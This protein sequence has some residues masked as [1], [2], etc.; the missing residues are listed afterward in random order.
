MTD[1]ITSLDQ[2]YVSGDLSLFPD[3]L[4]DKETLYEVTNNATTTLKQGLPF[5]GTNIIVE[6]ASEFPSQGIVRIGPEAGESGNAEFVY[7]GSRTNFVLKELQRGFADSSQYRWPAHTPVIHAVMSEH[8]NATKDA[9]LN[10][11]S[12]VGIET[13]PVENSLSKQVHDLEV[14]YLA[15]KPVFRA[16][17]LKGPPSL[18]VSF[19]NLCG[20]HVIRHLWDFG[21]GTKSIESNPYHTYLT[22]GQYTV[23]LNVITSTG[24]QGLAT[25][26]NYITVSES[27]ILPF[28]Y[29]VQADTTKPAY[30]STTADALVLSGDLT[31]EAATFNFVDQT[32]GNILQRY[33][34]FDDGEYEFVDDP[35]IHA[36]THVYQDP[37]EYQ[38]SLLLIYSDEK[39]SRAFLQDTVVVL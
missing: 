2:G 9:I 24:G 3:A 1:R 16:Y 14:K 19:K 39:L 22:E 35:N 25:K 12:K 30:S 31:A 34:I 28:F 7:Y 32:D 27:E 5:N 17:P 20:G 37:G 36:T 18:K 13:N 11:Q 15:P 29:V 21:D 8:H 23:K 10:I 26:M 4:D 33:W 6:D 38:P